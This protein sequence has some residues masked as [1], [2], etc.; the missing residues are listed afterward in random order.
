MLG[1]FGREGRSFFL[2]RGDVDEEEN[3]F[4]AVF[5]YIRTYR[6]V[7]VAGRPVVFIGFNIV[8]S[9]MMMDGWGEMSLSVG[10]QQCTS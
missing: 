5:E 6:R 7:L 4:L 10:L 8:Q 2:E 3:I 9:M 1:V